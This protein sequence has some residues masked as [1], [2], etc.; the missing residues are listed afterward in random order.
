MKQSLIEGQKLF[1]EVRKISKE[2][3]SL[4]TTKDHEKSTLNIT[5]A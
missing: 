4:I 1:L 3:V 5:V 2:K